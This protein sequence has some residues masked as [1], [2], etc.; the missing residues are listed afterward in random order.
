LICWLKN[1]GW[2]LKS[3]QPFFSPEAEEEQDQ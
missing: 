3:G 2:L 1:Q